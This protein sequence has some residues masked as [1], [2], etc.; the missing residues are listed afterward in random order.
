MTAQEIEYQSCRITDFSKL[1]IRDGVI[2]YELY[3]QDG[4]LVPMTIADTYENRLFVSYVQVCDRYTVGPE[5]ESRLHDS[6]RTKR[7]AL[8]AQGIEQG[9]SKPEVGGSIPSERAT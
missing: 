2:Y 3:Q 1:T 8:V 9:P 6:P 5:Y 4:K 7:N